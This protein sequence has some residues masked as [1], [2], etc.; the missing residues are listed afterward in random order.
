MLTLMVEMAISEPSQRT[1]VEILSTWCQ[2]LK[3][4]AF[5]H[6]LH[7]GSSWISSPA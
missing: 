5:E 4:K 7:V 6:I 2:S 3:A 1:G